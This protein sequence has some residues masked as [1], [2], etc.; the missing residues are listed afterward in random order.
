VGIQAEDT[1]KGTCKYSTHEGERM[2][3]EKARKI[4]ENN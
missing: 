4:L 3:L 2:F 1:N